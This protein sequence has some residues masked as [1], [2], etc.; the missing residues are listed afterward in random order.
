MKNSPVLVR[1]TLSILNFP[2][3]MLLKT[4]LFEARGIQFRMDKYSEGLV[5]WVQ[6]LRQTEELILA[7]ILPE[8][9]VKAL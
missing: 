2:W 9:I 8:G 3:Q 5:K 1:S 7:I 6:M 4:V